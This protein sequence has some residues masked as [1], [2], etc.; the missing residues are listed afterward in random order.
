MSARG[1]TD[2]GNRIVTAIDEA[3]NRPGEEEEADDAGDDEEE[4]G[5]GKAGKANRSGYFLEFD[6]ARKIAQGLGIH[7]EQS[8]SIV[9]VK[10]DTARLLPVGERTRHLFGKDSDAGPAGAKKAKKK[11]VQKSLF[12]ELDAADAGSGGWK[13]LAGPPPGATVLD[14]LHQAMILFGA[15]RGELLKRFLVDEGAGKDN[16][17]WKLAQALAAPYPAGMDERRWVEGMLAQEG[18]G[19]VE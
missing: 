10:G 12:E 8:A 16:R 7:L 2:L 9:E 5:T 11:S 15:G 3:H 1:K 6:A 4:S 17:F 13:D 18:A 14:R 19:V